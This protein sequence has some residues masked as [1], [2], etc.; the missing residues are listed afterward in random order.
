MQKNSAAFELMS[1][2]WEHRQE[3]TGHSWLRMNQGLREGLLLAVK[4]GLAFHEDDIGKIY[5]KFRGGYWFGS[6]IESFY[7]C[8]VV[9]GNRS[10]WKAYE[11]WASRTPFIYKPASL[12][13]Q[14]GGGGQ[15]INNPARLTIG[16]EFSWKGE[17]IR[18]TS[19][20]DAKGYL[21]AQ[22]YQWI[23]G[24]ECSECEQ[25]LP[26]ERGESKP[27]H[28]FTITHDDLLNARKARRA[29][30]AEGAALP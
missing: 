19:F 29:K 1:H 3:A 5:S 26:C 10:A 16:C 27:L 21:T 9:Y 17:T 6:N 11:C 2:L 12:R 23:D 4:L 20:N 14:W 8:A 7:T 30:E 15:G 18:V 13:D 22:S 25:E 28:R 24:K